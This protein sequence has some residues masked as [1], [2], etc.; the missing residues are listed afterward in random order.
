MCVFENQAEQTWTSHQV[1]LLKEMNSVAGDALENQRRIVCSLKQRQTFKGIKGQVAS[2]CKNIRRVFDAISQ[3]FNKMSKSNRLRVG[4][5]LKILR[6]ELSQSLAEGSHYQN[7]FTTCR[8]GASESSSE[9]QQL[10]RERAHFN[11]L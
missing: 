11:C 2:I 9:I 8:S 7:L 4:K 1:T 6:Q 5:K 10:R 3:K